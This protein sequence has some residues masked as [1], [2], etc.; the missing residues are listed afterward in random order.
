MLIKAGL[1][2]SSLNARGLSALDQ[3]LIEMAPLIGSEIDEWLDIALYL[4]KRIVSRTPYTTKLL[5]LQRDPR[6]SSQVQWSSI[7]ELPLPSIPNSK[8]LTFL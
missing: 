5:S 1:D 8:I 3:C 4:S 6:V 2:P 7:L